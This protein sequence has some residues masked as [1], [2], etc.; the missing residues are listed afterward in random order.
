MAKLF[1]KVLNMKN[2]RICN[3][4]SAAIKAATGKELI[5]EKDCKHTMP[6]VISNKLKKDLSGIDWISKETLNEREI[7]HKQVFKDHLRL[8]PEG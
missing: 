7:E 2:C 8:V 5:I 4:M 1:L 3:A 6:A